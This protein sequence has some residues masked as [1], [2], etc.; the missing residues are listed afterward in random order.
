MF[1]HVFDKGLINAITLE[2]YISRN[3]GKNFML[4]T[5][6]ELILESMQLAKI[7]FRH[8]TS[9]HNGDNIFA[10]RRKL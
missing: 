7:L 10:N 5:T 3:I 6:D 9:I 4:K 1:D 2:H 8:Q